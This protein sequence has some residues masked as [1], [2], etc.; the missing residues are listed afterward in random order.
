MSMF[1]FSTPCFFRSEVI[2]GTSYAHL[3]SGVLCDM[4]MP[5]AGVNNVTDPAS[6]DVLAL[7]GLLDDGCGEEHA[8]S[9]ISRVMPD[10]AAVIRARTGV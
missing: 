10:T 9:V 3:F 2:C 4:V 8:P 1:C 7:V 5:S 6:A